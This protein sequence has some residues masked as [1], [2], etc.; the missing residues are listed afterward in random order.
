[1]GRFTADQVASAIGYVEE[2]LQLTFHEEQRIA[3]EKFVAEHDLFVALPTSFGK[4]LIFQ[5]MPLIFDYLG[6]QSNNHSIAVVISPLTSLTED[7]ISRSQKL[8]LKAVNLS[9]VVENSVDWQS[10]VNGEF[11]IVYSSPEKILSDK[12]TKLL[13][14]SHYNKHLCGIFIDEGHCIAKW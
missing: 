14:S 11:S 2:K 1:M 5:S 3:I 10:V 8:G 6:H 13:T 9:S 7:Q 12:G 4:S